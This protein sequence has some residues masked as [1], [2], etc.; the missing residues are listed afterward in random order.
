MLVDL[1]SLTYLLFTT[2]KTIIQQVPKLHAL[3]PVQPAFDV[4]LVGGL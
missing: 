3:L 1:H 4:D 2:R